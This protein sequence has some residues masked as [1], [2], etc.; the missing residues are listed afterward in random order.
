M[1][2][3]LLQLPAKR[4][5]LRVNDSPQLS[6]SKITNVYDDYYGYIYKVQLFLKIGGLL[7]KYKK[8]S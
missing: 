4:R 8:R 5:S 3:A 2:Y 1:A 7:R 6:C